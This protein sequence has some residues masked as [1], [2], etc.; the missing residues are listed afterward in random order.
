[1]E[2]SR[3]DRLARLLGSRADRRHLGVLT[4]AAA[5]PAIAGMAPG[6]EAAR[7]RANGKRCSRNR[8]GACCSGICKR[9]RDRA[10]RCARN[11]LARGCTVADNACAETSSGAIPCPNGPVGFCVV[12]GGKPICVD[13][14]ECVECDGDG[15]C[16]GSQRC[17]GCPSCRS[18]GIATAC[19]ELV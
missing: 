8:P 4:A 2:G 17:I 12:A 5:M 13:R 3:F 11:R 10:S 19:I 7:C 9:G 18:I 15:D 1:M 6:A 16:P 14:A